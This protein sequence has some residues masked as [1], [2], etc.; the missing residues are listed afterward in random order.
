M[1]SDIRGFTTLSESR[2]PEQIVDLLNRYFTLQVEVIFRYNGTIDKFIGDCIMAFWGAPLDNPQ[3]ALDAVKAAVEMSEV[4]EKFKQEL[5]DLS[6][7]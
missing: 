5:G 4:L 3:H 1:F 6:R 7:F 2:T